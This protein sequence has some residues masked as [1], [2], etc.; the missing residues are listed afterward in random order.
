MTEVERICV[1][2][3][4]Q[5]ADWS[6]ESVIP[7]YQGRGERI[8]TAV[9]RSLVRNDMVFCK[10]CGA[11]LGG[12][13]RA[14]RPTERFVGA[15]DPVRPP[16]ITQRLVGQGP[17]ALP[18]AEKTCR[19]VE[20]AGPYGWVTGG[21]GMSGRCRHRP[22]R[23]R[24]KRCNGRAAARVAPTKALQ[25]VQ[26]AGDRK[27]RPYESVT[28]DAGK[29]SPVTASPCQPPLGKAGGTDCHTSESVTGSQ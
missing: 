9:N 8:A 1:S 7:L 11:R 6:W 14:P 13:V 23:K 24:N 5:S 15:D 2:F 27:G 17:C 28:R 12:G 22:L 21:C 19:A 10:E 25:G 20:D 26:W 3:R 4:D 29:E 18:G 16:P